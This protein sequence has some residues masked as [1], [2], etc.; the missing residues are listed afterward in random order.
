VQTCALPISKRQRIA[1]PDIAARSA[2]HGVALRQPLR[3]QDVALLAVGVDQQRD[4]RGAV[5]IVLDLGDTSRDPELVALE[6]DLAIHPLV[7]TTAVT[8]R[9]VTL[10]V[11]ATRLLERLEQRLFRR[12]PGDLIETG[13]RP[14]PGP[15]R[16]RTKLTNAHLSPRT[17]RVNRRPST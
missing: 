7:T 1:D 10:V 12:R 17:R 3:V 11:A 13:D 15:C 2:G 8:H 4:S 5:R 6:V 9:D 16:N 14:E